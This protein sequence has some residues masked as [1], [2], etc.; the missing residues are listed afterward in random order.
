[1]DVKCCPCFGSALEH[2]INTALGA[3]SG[4]SE[5]LEKC[6][7]VARYFRNDRHGSGQYDKARKELGLEHS[8]L[9][10][11]FPPRWNSTVL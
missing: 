10:L 8:K 3:E 1:M 5:L 11:D 6:R 2:C 4:I 9:K 7:D